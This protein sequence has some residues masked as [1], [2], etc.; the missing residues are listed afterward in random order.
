MRGTVFLSHEKKANR[1][2]HRNRRMQREK[3]EKGG[4]LYFKGKKKKERERRSWSF[5]GEGGKKEKS[6]SNQEKGKTEKNVFLTR[7]KKEGK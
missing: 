2:A 7:K 4:P 6:A 5:R 3:K 1:G